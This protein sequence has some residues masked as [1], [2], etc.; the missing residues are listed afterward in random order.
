MVVSDWTTLAINTLELQFRVQI[1]SSSD[2]VLAMLVLQPVTP[3]YLTIVSLNRAS[4]SLSIT[5]SG[6]LSDKYELS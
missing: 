2:L 6:L 3:F 5:F 4:F 1:R